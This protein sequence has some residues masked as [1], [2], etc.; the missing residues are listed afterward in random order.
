M[1]SQKS[2]AKLFKRLSRGQTWA[3][4]ME[5]RMT[6]TWALITLF[7]KTLI[8]P[9][10]SLKRMRR[11]TKSD[12]LTLSKPILMHQLS[13]EASPLFLGLSLSAPISALMTKDLRSESHRRTRESK[14]QL[15]R[16][17]SWIEPLPLLSR[18]M[19]GKFKGHTTTILTV[20]T[21][22]RLRRLWSQQSSRVSL[23][24]NCWRAQGQEHQKWRQLRTG[25]LWGS[26]L[27]TQMGC[28]SFAM[29]HPS[30]SPTKSWRAS[31][32]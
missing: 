8:Q 3:L 18:R 22:E 29:E 1:E 4:R 7:T 10:K 21:L 32:Y 26:C 17:M 15:V 16:M 19:M 5:T 25:I 6:T 24:K 2:L 23:S 30:K 28:K 20:K 27:H 13:R 14:L 12:S 11:K 9:S 31:D